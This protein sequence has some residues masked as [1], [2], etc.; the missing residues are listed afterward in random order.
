MTNDG[1]KRGELFITLLQSCHVL[2]IWKGRQRQNFEPLGK[3]VWLARKLCHICLVKY[4]QNHSLAEGTKSHVR[5]HC[6]LKV[7]PLKEPAQRF[8]KLWRKVIGYGVRLELFLD[9]STVRLQLCLKCTF[10]ILL[11]W[12]ANAALLQLKLSIVV[13]GRTVSNARLAN[14]D[15]AF[16]ESQSFREVPLNEAKTAGV[17]VQKK[18]E[19]LAGLQSTRFRHT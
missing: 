16:P 17:R 9:I 4:C 13:Q 11:V 1:R 5:N 6:G 10:F 18:D 7:G 14:Y 8:R 15:D 2:T 3:I 12:V 19:S